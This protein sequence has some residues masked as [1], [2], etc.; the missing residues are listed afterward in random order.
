MKN[1][2]LFILATFTL[3][4]VSCG[5]LSLNQQNTVKE[6]YTQLSIGMY[7]S[8]NRTLSPASE[9]DL[10]D[11]KWTISFESDLIS[12]KDEEITDG[13]STTVTL[14]NGIYKISAKSKAD[15]ADFA[16]LNFSGSKTVTLDGNTQNISIPVSLT[17]TTD[18]TG[19]I[20]ADTLTF[21]E[22][23][24]QEDQAVT[25]SGTITMEYC[26]TLVSVKDT[27]TIFSLELDN[28]GESSQ[29]YKL[30]STSIPS[31]YYYLELY[32]N[33]NKSIASSDSSISAGVELLK[34][35]KLDTPDTLVEIADGVATDISGISISENSSNK[36]Y[37]ATVGDSI[38][39]GVWASYPASLNTL[40][41]KL[42][43]TTDW[44]Y[45]TIYI[46]DTRESTAES[47]DITINADC[48][49]SY[50]NVDTSKIDLKLQLSDGSVEE[51]GTIQ[52]SP[53]SDYLNRGIF[54][55]NGEEIGHYS[56]EFL[57][58][59]C[60]SEVLINASGT[61]YRPIILHD[62]ISF[63]CPIEYRTYLNLTLDSADDFNPTKYNPA[64]G[65]KALIYFDYM[66]EDVEKISSDSSF[67]Y[68]SNQDD[69]YT[70]DTYLNKDKT[71]LYLLPTNPD[72]GTITVGDAIPD[73]SIS[74]GYDS[75]KTYSSGQPFYIY[76]DDLYLNAIPDNDISFDTSTTFV[77][78]INNYEID[79]D[80]I[81]LTTATE[82]LYSSSNTLQCIAF[83]GDS[84]KSKN[85]TLS[86]VEPVNSDI[87]YYKPNSDN[88]QFV[89]SF[90]SAENIYESSI[91]YEST[92]SVAIYK[93]NQLF[94]Y[95]DN[96][97]R[98][99][100]NPDTPFFSDISV[101][102]LNYYALTDSLYFT[103]RSSTYT[104][105]NFYRI[106]GISDKSEISTDDITP[107]YS[108]DLSTG[109]NAPK[110]IRFTDDYVV[111]VTNNDPAGTN[112]PT[113]TY[114]CNIY[115]NNPEAEEESDRCKVISTIT[116]DFSSLTTK[117]LTIKDLIINE[118]HNVA[119]VLIKDYHKAYD[120]S[121]ESL[122][123]SL[124][125][126]GGLLKIPLDTENNST[127]T[128]TAD[129]L[130]GWDET[131]AI[132]ECSDSN[133]DHTLT[134]TGSTDQDSKKFIAP[135]KFVAIRDDELIIGDNGYYF[136]SDGT[137]VYSSQ[138]VRV[139]VYD[140]NEDTLNVLEDLTDI[141]N[142]A[143]KEDE[144]NFGTGWIN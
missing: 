77:W 144:A 29:S 60:T 123:A 34:T 83:C 50:A 136:T 53:Y 52:K 124:Y 38:Y 111:S 31:G 131:V 134:V 62:G 107:Y 128:V 137:G 140:L 26:A 8:Q 35:I 20:F 119:F 13:L 4:L 70:Y 7:R 95:Y 96:A 84:I 98:S 15:T 37:Y 121:V 63:I 6:G 97:L 130:I 1:L 36:T 73:F 10:E 76:D 33:V 105:Y 58:G 81:N 46:T 30:D 67:S 69:T 80:S 66:T 129:N 61:I 64:L 106:K 135:Q 113:Y 139:F 110:Q 55:L 17:K 18:G 14:P 87:L 94:Y 56:Y 88:S 24:I 91:N 117:K 109:I 100:L 127:I 99:T 79:G 2:K 68:L 78:L 85:F 142:E 86:A 101:D 143:Y 12:V 57:P 104:D 141:Q 116:L 74:V 54:T 43:S 44:Y 90:E 40:L 132:Y 108:I 23:I 115:E 65:G 21:P 25:S 5:N 27:L 71:E 92:D 118:K 49:E 122:E 47:L 126:H 112:L 82:A 102:K 72:G 114:T 32:C 133:G 45:A 59:Q 42:T 41:K 75:T 125:S 11:F 16:G 51:V 93:N 3:F 89:Y 48:L 138:K 19:T 22:I 120:G 103:N 9:I 28:S 39:N